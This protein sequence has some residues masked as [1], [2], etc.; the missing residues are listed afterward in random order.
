M[1]RFVELIL[2]YRTLVLTLLVAITA[3]ALAVAST[4]TMSTQLGESLIGDRPEFDSYLEKSR[5]FRSDGLVVVAVEDPDMLGEAS[6]ARL[7]R[8][9]SALEE[10]P[11]IDRVQS[12]L[13]ASRM[14]GDGGSLSL[15]KYVAEAEA[16]P[17]ARRQVQDDLCSDPLVGRLFLSQDCLAHAVVMELTVDE[18]RT[19]ERLPEIVD[20]VLEA[21][22]AAGH[23]RAQIHRS[24]FTAA[25]AE[26]LVALQFN[27]T[28]IFPVVGVVLLLVVWLLFRRLWPAFV[29]LCVALMAVIWTVGFIVA[30]EGTLHALVSL[31]PPVIL[32][33]AFSDV[34]HLCSAYLILLERGRSKAEAIRGAATEVGKACFLTSATTFVGFAGFGLVPQPAMRLSAIAAA[35][36]VGVALLI[37]VTLVPV[38]LSFL[39]E[40]KPLRRGATATAHELLD[41]LLDR[42]RRLA[43]ARPGRV[44]A[45]FGI[46][47]ILSLAGAAG[48]TFD[49]DFDKRF[50]RENSLT[51]DT[52][53]FKEHFVGSYGLEV[54]V[55]APEGRDLLDP[56]RFRAVAGYQETLA[57]LPGIDS[58]TSLVDLMT[59]VHRTMAP[60][61]AAKDPLPDSR[62]LMA[63]YLLLFES[64]GGEELDSVVDFERR[65][66][67]ISLRLGTGGAR[68]TA[69]TGVEAARLAPL[70]LG[71]EARAEVTGIVFLL[72]YFFDEIVQGQQMGVLVSFLLIA[73]LMALGLRSL[74][75]GALSMVPNLLPVLVLLGVM[76]AFVDHIDSDVML[77]LIIAMGIG[78]DDTIHFLMRYRVELDRVGWRDEAVKSTFGF[79][80]RGILM[81]SVILVAGFLPCALSS[82]VTMVYLGTL[83]PLALVVALLA[84]VLLVPA[85][86][87]KGWLRLKPATA[88]KR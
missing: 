6:L 57:R 60:A 16:D 81:T 55:E 34:V 69:R 10:M 21:F 17:E 37:A 61:R 79:A 75:A 86:V 32:V 54:Y 56:E 46:V 8:T 58:A 82:Y 51:R 7:R 4:A 13:D 5:K 63:Q 12:I 31:V 70:H 22:V 23:D 72:G 52:E 84:D 48:F 53:W 73:L 39:P 88:L 65:E 77:I 80:G 38:L 67:V 59:E 43:G 11:D 87:Q 76:G 14:R 49:A 30:L 68:E 18:N 3:A 24:G 29:A 44:I 15:R 71:E 45:A 40:P 20:E 42:C 66:M 62:E 9:V 27:M 26:S 35:F 41:R 25:V 85:L 78:V 47:T 33:V 28:T 50:S 19:G 64:A 83:L 2:R 1:E 74:S 36:G